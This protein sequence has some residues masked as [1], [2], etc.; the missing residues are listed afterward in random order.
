MVDTIS[1]D[2]LSEEVSR[3]QI[4]IQDWLTG[5]AK[6]LDRVVL[7]SD[8]T[9]GDVI[10]LLG[11]VLGGCLCIIGLIGA[12]RIRHN[13][14]TQNLYR[15]TLSAA[16][17]YILF[18]TMPDLAQITITN[19]PIGFSPAATERSLALLG[20]L[21]VFSAFG[22]WLALLHEAFF[23]QDA[24]PQPRPS[25]EA[26]KKTASNESNSFL[27]GLF[28]A[29]L[30]LVPVY[31]PLLI[32]KL[33]NALKYAVVPATMAFAVTWHSFEESFELALVIYAWSTGQIENAIQSASVQSG[34]EAIDR[35][36]FA[37]QE[38][39]NKA[40]EIGE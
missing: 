34:L 37:V 39:G 16:L 10:L 35:L 28:A 5:N 7:G 11:I 31:L 9:V 13:I 40:P 3:L 36:L 1:T 29:V 21:C 18:V 17:L 24:R 32:A 25:T 2:T 27:A 22:Y 4:A 20:M 33:G 12:M 23:P 26:D 14:R 6:H 15:A 8:F 19:Q 38:V 30:L